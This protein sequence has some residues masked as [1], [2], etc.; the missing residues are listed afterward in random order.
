M[1]PKNQDPAYKNDLDFIFLF[2]ILFGKE[3]LITEFQRTNLYNW[4]NSRLGENPFYSQMNL[5]LNILSYKNLITV[6]KA[7]LAHLNFHALYQT[8]YY[9]HV[10]FGL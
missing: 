9:V 4:S 7:F 5:V 2:W 8:C 10:S 6:L 1:N 3:K